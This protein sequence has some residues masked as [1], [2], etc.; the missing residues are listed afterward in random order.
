M[1]DG[2]QRALLKAVE[3]GSY[4][5]AAAKVTSSASKFTSDSNNTIHPWLLSRLEDYACLKCPVTYVTAFL[6]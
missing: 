6:T 5:K 2:K 4:R 1:D 3:S